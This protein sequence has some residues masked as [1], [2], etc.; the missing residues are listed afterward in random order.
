VPLLPQFNRAKQAFDILCGYEYITSRVW[1]VRNI[2]EF[3]EKA[4][5][6]EWQ[7]SA[8]RATAFAFGKPTDSKELMPSFE[9]D[10][11]RFINN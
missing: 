2:G 5:L 7:T 11:N 3:D 1:C 10:S 4:N 8:V 6:Q 9:K